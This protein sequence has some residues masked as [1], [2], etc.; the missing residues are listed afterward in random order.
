MIVVLMNPPFAAY[1]A[2]WH[3]GTGVGVVWA[4]A[5]ML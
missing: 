2:N 5:V 1:P 3:D 4:E